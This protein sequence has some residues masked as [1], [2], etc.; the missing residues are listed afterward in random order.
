MNIIVFI[1]K[2]CRKIIRMYRSY[3]FEKTICAKN[4][5]SL[6]GK[7]TLIN[8]NIRIG[9]DVVIYPDCMF[10]GDGEIVIGD[11]VQIGNG[12]IIYSSKS[13]GVSIGSNTLIAAYSYIIDT[14]HGTDKNGLIR[15]NYN[16]ISKVA[17]G[18]D[19]WLGANVCVL[20]GSTIGNGAVI[21]AKSMVKGE[22]ESNSISVGIPARKIAVRK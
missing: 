18:E 9:K 10:F 20:R 5:V 2:C 21:G 22:I 8:R 12:T 11:N 19:C 3:I 13:G 4:K 16:K 7:V 1:D 6:I 14:D 15:N 17:I